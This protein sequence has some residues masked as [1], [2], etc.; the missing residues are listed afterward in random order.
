V[1]SADVA[2]SPRLVLPVP[3]EPADLRALLRAALLDGVG[4]QER[5]GA[6]L[7]VGDV[8]WSAWG[9]AL[10]GSGLPREQFDVVLR[11]YRREV[12]FWVLGDRI[13]PQ[14]ASGLGGR[15]VRRLP[16]A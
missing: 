1:S 2:S 3:A 13:W 9:D 5:F 12:W 8:L 15:L 7:G 16:L 6:E 11:G 4:W 14:M 10:S